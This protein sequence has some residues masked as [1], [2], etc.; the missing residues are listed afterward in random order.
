M[1]KAK[2]K[3]KAPAKKAARPPR[4]KAEPRPIN[5]REV[6]FCEH[7]RL[8]FNAG[9]AYTA[10]GYDARGKTAYNAGLRMLKRPQV[11]AYLAQRREDLKERMQ[12][13]HDDVLRALADLAFFNL[14]DVRNEDGSFKPVEE[15]PRRCTAAIAGIELNELR[16]AEGNVTGRTAKIKLVDKVGPLVKIG[17]QI[18]MFP[19][20]VNV[21]GKVDHTHQTI[22]DVLQEID[23]A[24][25]GLPAH[26]YTVN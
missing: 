4:A 15:W 18:G 1:T 24:D 22:A 5:E 13:E 2:P 7:Y 6:A 20:Q 17:Q 26:D 16:D 19:K 8:H 21:K 3:P 14:A 11:Q 12:L 23:G 25:T 10:A 9:A